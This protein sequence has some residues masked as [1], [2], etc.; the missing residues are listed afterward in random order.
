MN[1]QPQLGQEKMTK[2]QRN[3]LKRLH[4]LSRPMIDHLL[5]YC[6][7]AAQEGSFY[8]NEKQ[9]RQRHQRIVKWLEAIRERRSDMNNG[10]GSK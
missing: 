5:S 7:W 4:R 2:S 10:E 3:K 1:E 6:E 8:G 9:F